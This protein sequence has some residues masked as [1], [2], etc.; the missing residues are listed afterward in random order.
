VTTLEFEDDGY[1]RTMYREVGTASAP[2]SGSS[3]SA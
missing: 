1:A 3:S 2:S